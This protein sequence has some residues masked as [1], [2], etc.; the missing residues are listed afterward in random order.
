METFL[1]NFRGEWK[2]NGAQNSTKWSP[3]SGASISL[4]GLNAPLISLTEMKKKTYFKYE[5][6]WSKKLSSLEPMDIKYFLNSIGPS[7][8]FCTFYPVVVIMQI[9]FQDDWIIGTPQITSQAQFPDYLYT[10]I[11]FLFHMYG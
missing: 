3:A 9:S 8:C 1:V 11:G 2:E 6:K 10:K 7:E 4:T 5:Y